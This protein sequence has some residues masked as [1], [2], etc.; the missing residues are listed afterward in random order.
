MFKEAQVL[1]SFNFIH[2]NTWIFELWKAIFKK[3]STVRPV[4]GGGKFVKKLMTPDKGER[5][6]RKIL[7]CWEWYQINGE[8][9]QVQARISFICMNS[10]IFELIKLWKNILIFKKISAARPLREW[11]VIFGKK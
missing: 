10:W 3:F 8:G 11:G 6:K 2:I 9:V 1:A 5:I 7:Y 4:S